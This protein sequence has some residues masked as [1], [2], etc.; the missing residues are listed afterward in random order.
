MSESE[1]KHMD[2]QDEKKDRT[3]IV[4]G[5][6]KTVTQKEL[7]FSAVVALADNLPKGPDTIYTIGYRRGHGNKPEGILVEGNT[8]TVKDQMIFNVTATNKS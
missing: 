7:S 5:R 2:L 4:N 6:P 1:E 3:V 8:V